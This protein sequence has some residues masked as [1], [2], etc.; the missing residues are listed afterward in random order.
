MINQ[1]PVFKSLEKLPYLAEFPEIIHLNYDVWTLRVT[2]EFEDIR[3]YVDFTNVKGFRVLDEGD[4][5][6][7]WNPE[8]RI[9]GW[10]WEVKSGGWFDL[11]KI[12]EGFVT[13]IL[14]GESKPNEYFILGITDCVNVISYNEPKITIIEL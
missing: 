13:G 12:R 3:V 14:D 8:S 2:A 6:E 7:F 5:L 10:L 11:E 1:I 4:L 9:K